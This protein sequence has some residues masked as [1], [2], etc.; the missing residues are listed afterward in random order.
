MLSFGDGL[1]NLRQIV[2]ALFG[3]PFSSGYPRPAWL[4][5]GVGMP[6][7]DY[8]A[9]LRQNRRS[10]DFTKGCV[11]GQGSSRAWSERRRHELSLQSLGCSLD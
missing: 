1:W 10:A 3:E 11:D 4:D 2:N 8:E 9:H 7:L 6:F 5:V